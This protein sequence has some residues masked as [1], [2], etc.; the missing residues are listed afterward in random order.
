MLG[1]ARPPSSAEP[2]KVQRAYPDIWP[3]LRP[4]APPKEMVTDDDHM[5]DLASKFRVRRC[6]LSGLEA[7]TVGLRDVGLLAHPSN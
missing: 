3:S 5:M 6:S 7:A 4:K 1:E 2:K